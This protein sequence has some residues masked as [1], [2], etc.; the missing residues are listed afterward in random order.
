MPKHTH[1]YRKGKSGI[2]T[3][4]CGKFRFT[5]EYLKDHPPIVEVKHIAKPDETLWIHSMGKRFQ[6]RA[7]FTDDESANSYMEGHRD[8][9]LIAE[10]GPFRIVANLHEGVTA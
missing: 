7:I 9:G 3:C 8:T 5:A 4:R 6:V 1:E 10:F 2:E